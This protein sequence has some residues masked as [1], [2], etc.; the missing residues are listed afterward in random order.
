MR[1]ESTQKFLLNLITLT[2]YNCI[3]CTYEV[4]VILVYRT[5]IY[6]VVLV[7]VLVLVFNFIISK[8]YPYIRTLGSSL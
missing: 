4:L 1:Y 2:C 7:L 5:S 8:A 6:R 3:Y